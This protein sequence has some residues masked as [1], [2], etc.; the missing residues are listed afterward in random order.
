MDIQKLKFPI[1]EFKCPEKISNTN[2]I[3]WISDIESFPTTIK[4]LTNELSPAQLNWKYRPE[5]WT[6]K[7]L[8]HHCADSHI[9]AISRFKIAL[10][11]DSPIIRPYYEDRWANLPDALEDDISNSLLLLEGLHSRWSILLRSLSAQ[12]LKLTFIHPEHNKKFSVEENI[13]NYAWHCNHHLAHI[14]LAIEAKG[15]YNK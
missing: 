10:T 11:E 13:G 3:Q 15:I 14:K 5:G 6:I 1:G 8:V 12:Q 2:I 7:Q 9:N 4:Q